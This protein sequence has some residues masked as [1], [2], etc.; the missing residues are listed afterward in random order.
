MNL[1]FQ[2]ANVVDEGIC[3][4][5]FPRSA[6]FVGLPHNSF[7]HLLS[8]GSNEFLAAGPDWHLE[9]K[10]VSGV[11][12]SLVTCGGIRSVTLEIQG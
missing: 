11:W 6:V 2:Q 5:D 8:L 10:V 7:K 12:R 1:I 3:Q 9:S 4:N